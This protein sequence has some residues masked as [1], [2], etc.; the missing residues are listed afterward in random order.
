MACLPPALNIYVMATDYKVYM[1]EAFSVVL[2]GTL[3]AIGSVT[4]V[5]YLIKT[6]VI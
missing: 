4:Y 6:Q 2:I 5:L 1:R 3:L